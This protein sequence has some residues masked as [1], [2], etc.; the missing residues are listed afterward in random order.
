[1]TTV[2]ISL[3]TE[4]AKRVDSEIHKHGFATR[5]EFIR[6]LIRRYFIKEEL[7]F[8]EFKPVPLNQ[9]K[10]ELRQ[11]G[12]YDERFISSLIKGLERSSAYEGKT[13]KS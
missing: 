3:P 6:S 2:T 1:M 7:E 11:T 13:F 12:K 10:S 8:E 9:L 4:I 5:S